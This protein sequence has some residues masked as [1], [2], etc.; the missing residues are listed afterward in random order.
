M[1]TVFIIVTLF[2]YCACLYVS[3]VRRIKNIL[4][5]SAPVAGYMAGTGKTPGLV[6]PGPDKRRRPRTAVADGTVGTGTMSVIAAA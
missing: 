2:I 3:P 6:Y 5:L 1:I 4:M